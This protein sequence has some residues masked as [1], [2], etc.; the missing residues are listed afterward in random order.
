MWLQSGSISIDRCSSALPP[1]F[2]VLH[3][4]INIRLNVAHRP[5]RPEM[6]ADLWY[7]I[8][9]GVEKI[10]EEPR[11][12]AFFPLLV[13]QTRIGLTQFFGDIKPVIQQLV[14]TSAYAVAQIL[15]TLGI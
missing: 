1:I 14:A 3:G 4:K 7:L 13:F 6:S 2:Y 12:A 15:D 8:E 9:F 11:R 5:V 10:I